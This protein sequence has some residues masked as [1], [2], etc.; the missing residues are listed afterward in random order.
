MFRLKKWEYG[1]IIGTLLLLSGLAYAQ[2]AYESITVSSTAKSLT[3]ATYGRANRAF[4][5]VEGNSIRYTLD[6][7]NTPTSAGV[8][9]RRTSADTQPLILVNTDEI[10][11]FRAV[12][13]SA[14]DATIKV[15]YSS[16]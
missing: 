3:T 11:N 4:I 16:K 6:G 12:R 15:T 8:G 5:T 14:T 1:L 10:K 2:Y 13:S 7:T 9:H